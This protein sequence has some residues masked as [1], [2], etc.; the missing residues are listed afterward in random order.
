MKY[1]ILAAFCLAPLALSACGTLNGMGQDLESAGRGIQR[2][3]Q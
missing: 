1:I 2:T 3:V